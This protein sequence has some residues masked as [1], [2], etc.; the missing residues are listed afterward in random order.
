MDMSTQP[1]P[2]ASYAP[3]TRLQESS[4]RGFE[5]SE[6]AARTQRLQTAMAAQGLDALMLTTEA[7]MN[8]IKIGLPRKLILSKRKGLR[9]VIFT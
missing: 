3:V 9:E 5:T 7:G 4:M 6:F 8:C 1:N 2:K